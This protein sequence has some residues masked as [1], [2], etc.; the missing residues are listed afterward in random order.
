MRVL[1]CLPDGADR[2]SLSF[3]R[4][5]N[6]AMLI[7][8]D[9]IKAGRPLPPLYKASR[10]KGE[11]GSI[12]YLGEPWAGNGIEEFAT[13]WQVVERGCGDCDDLV[14][15]RGAELIASGRPCHARVLRETELNK[16][17]T[18]LTRDFGPRCVEDPCLQRLGRPIEQWLIR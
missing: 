9:A 14:I 17:H 10:V 2:L 4:L 15:Y 7:N 1:V 16:Y 3:Q 6:A 13:P 12:I 11:P 18:Q 5:L 8:A